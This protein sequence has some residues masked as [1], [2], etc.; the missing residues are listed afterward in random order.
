L[1]FNL[2]ERKKSVE[3]R[4]RRSQKRFEHAHSTGAIKIYLAFALFRQLSGGRERFMPA[5]FSEKLD[6]LCLA[7]TERTANAIR[8]WLTSGKL[9]ERVLGRIINFVKEI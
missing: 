1:C 6:F 8:V 5:F 9:P 3:A 2:K 7:K 4:K